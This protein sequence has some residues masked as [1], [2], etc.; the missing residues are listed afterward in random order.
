ML[1]SIRL[2]LLL[3]Y[4]FTFSIALGGLGL[5]LHYEL[6]AIIVGAVDNHLHSEVQLVASLLKEGDMDFSEVGS[7]DYG[8]PLSG[9]YY[10][11]VSD[12]K[13]IARSPSLSIVDAYLPIPEPSFEPIYRMDVGPG[14]ERIRVLSQSFRVGGRVFTVQASESMEDPYAILNSFRR[15]LFVLFP[16]MVLV[17]GVLI[18]VI[19]GQGLKRLLYLSERIRGI[20]DR[21]LGER[22]DE[23]RFDRELRSLV[24]GFNTMLSR[25]EGAF[26]RQKEFFSNASHTL[27]TPVSII[28]S[29]CDVVLSRERRNEEYR[30]ALL[31]ISKV[32]KGMARIIDQILD[33]SRLDSRE[34]LKSSN[35][36]L[37][38]IAEDVVR[39]LSPSAIEKGVTLSFNGKRIEVEGNRERLLEALT[40]IVDNSIKYN[41][42]KGS[43][44][45]RVDSRDG[46]ALI[47]VSDT[48]I[49]IADDERE[50]I[51]DRFYRGSGGEGEGKGLGLSIARAIIEHHGGRIEVESEVGKGSRFFI[52]LPFSSSRGD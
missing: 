42:P 5:F 26:E 52:F 29:Y 31:Q 6:E 41:R 16:S 50:R 19:T 7:G 13:V 10:Q 4:G 38:G 32:A 12:G 49:G 45:I 30:E 21:N 36:D 39:L 33:L 20:S 46:W 24:R 17:M 9:H 3:L 8:V 15:N 48:G 40:N 23:G 11:V 22:L 1:R 51:F 18:W 44:D 27:K 35:I 2:R 43:V 28:K 14:K 25:L 34:F 47:T 37:L